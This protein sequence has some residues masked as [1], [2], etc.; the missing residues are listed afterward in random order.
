MHLLILPVVEIIDVLQAVCVRNDWAQYTQ[1]E[2]DDDL[3]FDVQGHL[4]SLKLRLLRDKS[5]I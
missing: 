4:I 2:T 5:P 3:N 1:K